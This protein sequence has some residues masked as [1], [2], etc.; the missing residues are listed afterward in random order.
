MLKTQAT[1]SQITFRGLKGHIRI[2]K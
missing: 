1:H 2:P